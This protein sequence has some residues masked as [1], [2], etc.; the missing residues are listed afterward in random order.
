MREWL[1]DVKVSDDFGSFKTTNFAR[2]D[3]EIVV[4][5]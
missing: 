3:V 2:M 1:T 5:I 4:F